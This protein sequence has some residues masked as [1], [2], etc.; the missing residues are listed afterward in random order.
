[1]RPPTLDHSPA[2]GN[3]LAGPRARIFPP[4]ALSHA[5]CADCLVKAATEPAWVKQIVNVGRA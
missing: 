1:M 5:D 2:T 4:K 3:Y